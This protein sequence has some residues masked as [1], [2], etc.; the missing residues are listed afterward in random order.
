MDP[1]RNAGCDR[2]MPPR[3][4]AGSWGRGDAA[5][6][7]RRRP[8]KKLLSAALAGAAMLIASSAFAEPVRLLVSVGH[9]MGLQAERPLKFADTDAARV[10]DVMVSMGGV[11]AEN[12]TVLNEPSAAGL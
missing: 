5:R 7:G 6:M 11:K 2:A 12:A 4:C 1:R 3:P 9:K 8:M 10:R